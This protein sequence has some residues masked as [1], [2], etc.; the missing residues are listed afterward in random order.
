MRISYDNVLKEARKNNIPVFLH[1]PNCSDV[2]E[3]IYSHDK[4]VRV[5]LR[6]REVNDAV[7]EYFGLQ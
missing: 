1:M 7:L 4:G 3:K 6:Y 2:F 5:I